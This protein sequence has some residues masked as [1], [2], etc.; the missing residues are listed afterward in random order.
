MIDEKVSKKDLSYLLSNKVSVEE[1]RK[2]LE[3]KANAHELN[4]ELQHLNTKVDDLFRDLNKKQQN[5]A[6][7]KDF[8][9]LQAQLELRATIEDVA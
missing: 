9:Y 2:V 5:C 4:L 1:L 6:L 8:A 3:N 7:Q